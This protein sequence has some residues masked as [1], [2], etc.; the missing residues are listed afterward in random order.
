[1]KIVELPQPTVVPALQRG[2]VDC[3]LLGEPIVTPAK[4]DVRDIDRPLDVAAKEFCISV[5]YASK[6]WMEADRERARR[7]V[8]AIYDTARWAHA[9]Q[10]ETCG[11]L[12]R[13]GKLDGDKM[14]G[15]IRTTYATAL[16][17]AYVQP[18]LNVATAAK[19]FD[20]PVDANALILK[21]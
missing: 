13:D 7:I 11:I 4:N 21:V 20:R 8:G 19:I 15:M 9:H 2:T 10:A 5:W 14:K 16:P 1:M 12:V 6:P 18:V 17:T 3:A